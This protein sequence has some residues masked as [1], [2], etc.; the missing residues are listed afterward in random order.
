MFLGVP[1][2]GVYC[3]IRI[4]WAKIAIFTL[5]TWKYLSSGE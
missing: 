5:Y 1:P 4:Q 3:T 2:L